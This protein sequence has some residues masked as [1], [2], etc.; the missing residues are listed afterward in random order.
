MNNTYEVPDFSG[1]FTAPTVPDSALTYMPENTESFAE[2]LW[3]IIKTAITEIKPEFADAGKICLSLI[4]IALLISVVNTFSN[5][6]SWI[7][8]LTR[9]VAI[10]LLLLEPSNSMIQL[11]IKTIQEISEYGKLL[12]PVMTAALSAQGGI[13][14]SAAIY[15]G[16]VVFNTL[17]ITMV[18]SIIV[19]ILFVYLSLCIAVSA[20]DNEMLGKIRDLAKWAMTWCLKIVL[21]AFTGYISIT[22]VISGAVDKSTL[23]VTKMTIS[24]IV[25]VVGGILSDASETILVS[26]GLMKNTAGI[27]GIFAFL[28]VC[29]HPFLQIG[30]LYLMLKLSGAI[31]NISGCKATVG[32]V[33][34]FSTGMGYVLA[35]TGTVCLLSLISLVC[36]VTGVG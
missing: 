30:V 5:K 28:A 31:C 32:L 20:V 22:K 24:S 33:Q 3:Y 14:T 12:F 35:M 34:N 26:V 11:G 18:E 9:S 7:V 15:T 10:G 4:A 2:G 36:F 6:S 25:P 8:R 27:Y 29:I 23:K 1:S 13:T 19:P 21:Y 16:T 17:L